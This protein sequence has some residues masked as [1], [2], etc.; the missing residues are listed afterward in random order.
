MDT[1]INEDDLKNESTSELIDRILQQRQFIRQLQAR[2]SELETRLSLVHSGNGK[3]VTEL[4]IENFSEEESVVAPRFPLGVRLTLL[5]F[6]I[7]ACGVIVLVFAFRPEVRVIV[8]RVQ[9]HPIGSVAELN[10]PAANPNDPA[11]A[12]FLVNDPSA[13]FLALDRRDTHSGCLV[14]WIESEEYFEDSCTGSHYTRSGEVI[15]GPAPHGLDRYPVIISDNN[16][17]SVNVGNLQSG[18]ER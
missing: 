4:D 17:V 12:I 2:I 9:E 15:D 13:G 14:S 5:A 8:G 11:R 18:P 3:A 10:L 16:E 1:P 6:A 7:V